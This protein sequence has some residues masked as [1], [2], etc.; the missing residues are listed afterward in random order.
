MSL[1]V[2]SAVLTSWSNTETAFHSY[3]LGTADPT[4]NH[5]SLLSTH[6]PTWHQEKGTY[7]LLDCFHLINCAAKLLWTAS[8]TDK[9]PLS[10]QC[11]ASNIRAGSLLQY[12]HNF[13][14]CPV[15]LRTGIMSGYVQVQLQTGTLISL[16]G[17]QVTF[18]YNYSS[19]SNL[20]LTRKIL[21]LH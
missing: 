1:I 8:N 3:K 17:K 7:N 11:M 20:S 13:L 15:P 21:L 14:H 9:I 6:I 10:E 4:L 5:S 19:L 12:H 16:T 18:R 2:W